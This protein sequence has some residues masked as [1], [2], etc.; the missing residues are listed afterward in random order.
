MNLIKAF[1]RTTKMMQAMHS[2]SSGE[3]GVEEDH[4]QHH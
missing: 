2:D 1:V 3:S 4:S